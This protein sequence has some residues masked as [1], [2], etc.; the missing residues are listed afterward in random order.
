MTVEQLIDEIKAR[1]DAARPGPWESQIRGNYASRVAEFFRQNVYA[2]VQCDYKDDEPNAEFV[3]HS[4]TDV[5]ALI[6]MLRL[7]IEQRN[8]L[9][10]DTRHEDAELIKAWEGK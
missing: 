9:C 5:P 6:R 8:M 4:R 7:A 2:K 3:A 1:A 10:A